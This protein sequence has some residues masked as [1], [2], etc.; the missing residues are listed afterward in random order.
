LRTTLTPGSLLLCRY[1]KDHLGATL[2]DLRTLKHFVELLAK[3][4][5]SVLEEKATVDTVRGYARR[6]TLGYE[7]ETGICIPE[8]V[9]KLVTNVS[10][11]SRGHYCLVEYKRFNANRRKAY[12]DDA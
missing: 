7:R 2:C 12:Q 4:A 10:I 5:D 8:Q 6:F 3:S 1:E 9:R 11:V